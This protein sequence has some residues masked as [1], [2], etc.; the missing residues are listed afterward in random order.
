MINRL[1]F[2]IGDLAAPLAVG[3]GDGDVLAVLGVEEDLRI[4][5]LFPFAGLEAFDLRAGLVAGDVLGDRIAAVALDRDLNAQIVCIRVAEVQRGGGGEVAGQAAQQDAQDHG[6]QEPVVFQK[7][8]HGKCLLVFVSKPY[9]T[10]TDY[11]VNGD[12]CLKHCKKCGKIVGR[13]P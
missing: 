1:A 6:K 7:L 9:Y 2:G 4:G 12:L 3:Q 13:H 11:T 8:A 5:G 10:K